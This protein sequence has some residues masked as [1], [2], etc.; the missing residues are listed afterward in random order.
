MPVVEFQPLGWRVRVP[1]GA[2]VVEAVQLLCRE[3]GGARPG[4]MS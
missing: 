4:R 2:T 3:L 1:E